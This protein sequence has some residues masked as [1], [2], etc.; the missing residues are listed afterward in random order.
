MEKMRKIP[1]DEPLFAGNEKKYISECIESGWV[2][3]QGSFVSRFEEAIADYLKVKY[4]VTVS[5]G[6]AATHMVLAALGIRSRDEVIVPT[7][8]FITTPGMI[9]SLGAKS[10]P[11]DCSPVRFYLNPVE[12]RKKIT[13]RTKA[14]IAVHLYGRP[15]DMAPLSEIAEKNKIR[16]IEDCSHSIGAEYNKKKTGSFGD[17]NFFSMHNK[18]IAAG[19]GGVIT[20][21][22]K[23]IFEK[24]NYLRSPPEDNRS[25]NSI[26][27]FSYRMSNLQAA[28]ALAQL[29]KIDELVARR[30]RNA[31][32]YREF[33]G[34]SNSLE[35]IPEDKDTLS[36]YWRNNL[37]LNK[38][39]RISRD[40]LIGKLELSGIQAR[41]VYSPIHMHP[42]FSNKLNGKFPVAEMLSKNGIDLPSSPKLTGGEIEFISKKILLFC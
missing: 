26:L 13:G 29:E 31:E 38:K 1:L 14:I 7:M 27:N 11:V 36:V 23:D 28:V 20:T 32:L 8:S 35:I 5:T 19:E 42:F 4:A 34:K 10:V 6:T 41:P 12:V 15:A 37:L 25:K 16:L 17:A 39:S 2:S 3:W 18:I 22:D 9:S 33:L 24:I 21:N 40:L 30:K